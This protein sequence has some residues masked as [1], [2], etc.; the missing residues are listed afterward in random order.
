MPSCH[1][2]FY[3]QGKEMWRQNHGR[4]VPR[5]S[6]LACRLDIRHYILKAEGSIKSFYEGNNTTLS[7]KLKQR[8]TQSFQLQM[9]KKRGKKRKRLP[10]TTISKSGGRGCGGVG[11]WELGTVMTAMNLVRNSLLY[12]LR[13]ITTLHLILSH[14]LTGFS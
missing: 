7:P 13:A 12:N 4:D 6:V 11:R 8:T 9:L 10:A 1:K 2:I 14:G 3:C 5:V